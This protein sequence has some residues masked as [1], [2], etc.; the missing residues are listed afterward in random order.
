MLDIPDSS[1]VTAQNT[2]IGI[3]LEQSVEVAKID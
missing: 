1:R 3:E 2:G